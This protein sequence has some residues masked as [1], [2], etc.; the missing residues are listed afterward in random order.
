[1]MI[2]G[3]SGNTHLMF[4]GGP[5]AL[6]LENLEVLSIADDSESPWTKKHQKIYTTH[7]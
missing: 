7:Q 5:A 2:P 1:M 4:A 6:P 3:L